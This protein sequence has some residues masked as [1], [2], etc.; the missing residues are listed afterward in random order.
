MGRRRL[1]PNTEEGLRASKRQRNAKYLSNEVVSERKR[2]YDREYQRRRRAQK[3]SAGNPDHPTLSPDWA[4]QGTFPL[5][6]N[7][8]E[9]EANSIE[10]R[11]ESQAATVRISEDRHDDDDDDDGDDNDEANDCKEFSV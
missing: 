3:R 11:R 5:R 1:I 4:S 2:N 7:E 9:I 8:N 10:D 6:Q